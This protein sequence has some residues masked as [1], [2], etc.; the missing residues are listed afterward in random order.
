MIKAVF[1]DLYETLITEWDGN[2]KKAVY[3]TDELGL[4]SK[5]FKAEWDN[6]RELRM[7]GTYPD[8]QS[9]LKDILN[10]HGKSS[11]RDMIEKVHQK[12][13]WAKT[14]PFQEMHPE[15]IELLATLKEKGKKLGLISNCAPEEVSSWSRSKLAD[16]FDAVV[17]SYEEKV[18]KPSPEIYHIASKKLGV[19]PEEAIFIGDGGSNELVGASEAGLKAYHATWFLPETISK[20]INGFPKLNHPLELLDQVELAHH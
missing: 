13:I 10:S 15:V 18:A 16:Y 9:V 17:F 19:T 11:D 14:V 4:D 7:N 12:R 5:I 1:F 6:R 8:H 2:Q 20:K 3:S